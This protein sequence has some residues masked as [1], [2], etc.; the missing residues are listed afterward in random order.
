MLQSRAAAV[1]RCSRSPSS[2]A[3]PRT[4]R[5]TLP[6]Q[7]RDP[8]YVWEQFRKLI[9]SGVVTPE[10]VGLMLGPSIGN[11]YRKTSAAI[12]TLLLGYFSVSTEGR[13]KIGESLI[14]HRDVNGVAWL[15]QLR[16]FDATA[17]PL[18]HGQYIEHCASNRWG[19]RWSAN[20]FL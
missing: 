4:A 13:A 8:A 19:R 6:N 20:R 16:P 18:T 3:T 9:D 14:E 11:A 12:S 7:V 15:W 1:A 17:V 5:W 10:N 2:V